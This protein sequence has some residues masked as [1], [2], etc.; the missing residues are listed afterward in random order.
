MKQV[1]IFTSILFWFVSV[2]AQNIGNNWVLKPPS[3]LVVTVNTNVNSFNCNLQDFNPNLTLKLSQKIDGQTKSFSENEILI[4]V[5]NLDCANKLINYDLQETLKAKTY[6]NIKLS[7]IEIFPG[8]AKGLFTVKL[9]LE[10]A[11]VKK[12]Y[13]TFCGFNRLQNGNT[14]NGCEKINLIDFGLQ[15]PEKFFGMVKVNNEI[16]VTFEFY[17]E[18]F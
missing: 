13:Q 15:P 6:P 14:L 5:A 3:K 2:S 1:L 9:S 8:K 16:E 12:Y 7:F 10:I 17:F 18:Q 4:P 11:G